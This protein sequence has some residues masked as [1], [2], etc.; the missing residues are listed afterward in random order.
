M[1]YFVSM[2]ILRRG[3]IQITDPFGHECSV[4]LPDRCIG[5][6]AVYAS[7]EDADAEN[8]G[9]P[10]LKIETTNPNPQPRTA[11]A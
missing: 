4:G 11:E 8:P 10:V 1:T 7:K 9:V 6:L 5:M 2:Q 3:N